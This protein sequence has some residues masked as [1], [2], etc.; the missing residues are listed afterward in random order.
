MARVQG[1]ELDFIRN[2]HELRQHSGKNQPGYPGEN[3]PRDHAVL[4]QCSVP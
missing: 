2:R 3:S 4:I 1:D